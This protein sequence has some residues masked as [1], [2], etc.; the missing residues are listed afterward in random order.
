MRRS[1]H[2]RLASLFLPALLGGVAFGP[3]RGAA[4]EWALLPA[5]D[6][7]LTTAN[8]EAEGGLALDRMNEIGHGSRSFLGARWPVGGTPSYGDGTRAVASFTG[9]WDTTTEERGSAIRFFSAGARAEWAPRRYA[10][11]E[12]PDAP[13]ESGWRHSASLAGQLLAYRHAGRSGA[14]AWAPQGELRYS[15]EW[16]EAG[17]VQFVVFDE[18]LGYDV[19]RSMKTGA[20]AQTPTLSLRGALFVLP[21]P[22][23][24]IL[25]GLE[26]SAIPWALAPALR[27]ASSGVE[28]A[29]SPFGGGDSLGAEL[30]LYAYPG[31]ES[32]QPSDLLRPVVDA[33]RRLV[34]LRLG[35]MV[36]AKWSLSE[37]QDPWNPG[38]DLGIRLQSG[39]IA[40]QY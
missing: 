11:Q 34:N 15:R 7:T 10:W 28:G 17:T 38:L 25:P 39:G 23:L 5:V 21:G 1:W 20:P 24:V 33:A 19:V 4:T 6:L 26:D 8:T 27:Y 29:W 16:R 37:A 18:E 14:T 35:F 36:A 32:G 22:N 30:W 12:N 13:S 3:S 2:S 31:G 40:Y 9:L